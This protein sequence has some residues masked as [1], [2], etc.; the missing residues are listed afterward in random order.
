MERLLKL[1]LSPMAFAMGFLWP[2]VTQSL[3]ALGYVEAGT[4]GLLVGAAVAIAFGVMAQTRGS[5]V[6]I[7]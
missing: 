2:L 4:Q 1:L 6:W 5:W 7:R 3:T